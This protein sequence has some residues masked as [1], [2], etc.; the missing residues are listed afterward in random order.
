MNSLRTDDR[1]LCQHWAD[2]FDCW[3]VLSG[4][5]RPIS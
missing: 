1:S 5:G 4:R 2:I 3:K